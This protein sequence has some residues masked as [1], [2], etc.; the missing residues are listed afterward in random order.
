MLKLLI[1]V[2]CGI[3]LL[4]LLIQ[5]VWYI[6]LLKLLIQVVWYKAYFIKYAE[7]INT[8]CVV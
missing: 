6:K 1:Q 3:K 7:V 4:K 8:S 5:V 2:V